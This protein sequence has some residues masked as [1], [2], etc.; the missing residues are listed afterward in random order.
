LTTGI[1]SVARGAAVANNAPMNDGWEHDHAVTF[2]GVVIPVRATAVRPSWAELPS[3]LRALVEA[4]AGEQV[5]GSWS[6][7]TGF[8]PGF[9]SRLDLADGSRI[10]VK[11]ASSAD[12]E[13]NGWPLSDAYREEAR[14]LAALPSGIGAPRLL[15]YR[16]VELIGI[17]WIV[18]ALEYVDGTPP[19]RPWRRG[20]LRLVL[21]KLAAT[22]PALAQAPP[23]LTLGRVEDDILDGL[24]TRLE[25]IGA[26]EHDEE[27]FSEVERLCRQAGQQL[28][29]ESIVHLDLRDDNVLIDHAREV[30]FVDWNWPALGPAWVDLV[31]LLISVAGD[32]IDAD[33]IIV[34]HPTS[35]DVD[36][37]A[38]DCLLAVLW[39]FWEVGRHQEVPKNS[40]HLRSHQTWYADATAT[41]LRARLRARAQ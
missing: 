2:D 21:D 7:G 30:W 8:T 33:A 6:A 14:K 1:K 39:A 22:A 34:E 4:T 38:V 37:E 11:A 10:F 13:E 17:R 15:W 25:R 27:L 20:E 29:G 32:G 40:P 3:P 41:W 31:C 5:I 36:P 26:R 35:R 16:D 24:D 12:D 28:T 18:I 9:A 19:R 23:G